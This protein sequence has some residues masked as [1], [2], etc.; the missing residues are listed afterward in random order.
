MRAGGTNGGD[1]IHF[2]RLCYRV[3]GRGGGEGDLAQKMQ[4]SG[5]A[6]KKKKREKYSARDR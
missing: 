5:I 3:G 4:R 1:Q 6:R 2:V